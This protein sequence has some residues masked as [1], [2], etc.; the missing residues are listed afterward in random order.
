[1][2]WHINPELLRELSDRELLDEFRWWNKMKAVGGDK[3]VKNNRKVIRA[4]IRR[5]GNDDGK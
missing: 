1:M 3:M 4:E 2:T 5:R